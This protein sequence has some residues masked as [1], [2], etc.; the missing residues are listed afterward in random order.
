MNEGA[1]FCFNISCLFCEY[2][3]YSDVDTWSLVYN[4]KELFMIDYLCV[5]LNAGLG[6]S[7]D[8]M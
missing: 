5:D 8:K 1:V 6:V 2:W 7:F 3:F 4:I